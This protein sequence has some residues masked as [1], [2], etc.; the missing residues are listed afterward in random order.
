MY[1]LFHWVMSFA[2][3]LPSSFCWMTLRIAWLSAFSPSS[4]RRSR[5]PERLELIMSKP[6]LSAPFSAV[7]IPT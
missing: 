1:S 2:V 3:A 6:T 4:I 5:D 7:Y